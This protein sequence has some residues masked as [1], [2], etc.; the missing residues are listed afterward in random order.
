MGEVGRRRQDERAAIRRRDVG[1]DTREER[2]GGRRVRL[3]GVKYKPSVVGRFKI[4]R[5][6]SAEG[7]RDSLRRLPARASG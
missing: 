4:S 5:E 3:D 6:V 7:A 1:R 2:A